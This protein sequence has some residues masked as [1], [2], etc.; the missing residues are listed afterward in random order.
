MP[1][2]QRPLLAAVAKFKPVAGDDTQ[3][4]IATLTTEETRLLA[5]DH[6]DS[7]LALVNGSVQQQTYVT[8]LPT[9]VQNR[10][11]DVTAAIIDGG[12]SHPSSIVDT[13]QV[14][15]AELSRLW[16]IV[17]N[18]GIDTSVVNKALLA[19]SAYETELGIEQRRILVSSQR[20]GNGD[21]N[22]ILRLESTC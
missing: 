4:R 14:A 3:V 10:E 12:F 9:D 7:C 15:N 17:R 18:K 13:E 5:S 2:A 21:E 11:V 1:E 6:P 8:F 20:R 22:K 16:T 19:V